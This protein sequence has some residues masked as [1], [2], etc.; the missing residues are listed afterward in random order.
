MNQLLSERFSESLQS[1]ALG[2][3]PIDADRK[4]VV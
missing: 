1:L 3:E 4:S 2:I